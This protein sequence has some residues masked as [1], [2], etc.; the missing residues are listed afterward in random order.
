MRKRSEQVQQ[1]YLE[2]L[3]SQAEEFKKQTNDKAQKEMQDQE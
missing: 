2:Q 1:K 3:K